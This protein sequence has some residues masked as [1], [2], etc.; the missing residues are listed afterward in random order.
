MAA[1]IRTLLSLFFTVASTLLSFNRPDIRAIILRMPKQ[2]IHVSQA[3]ALSDFA[4]LLTRVQAG[5][6]IIIEDN[7]R[8]VA[9]LTP[10]PLHPGRLLSD[11]ITSAEIC[12][13]N[14]TLD[15][16]FAHD[17]DEIISSHREPMRPPAW[18]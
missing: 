18:E 10:A 1:A 16:N 3:E 4:A 9:I 13:S 14:A 11:A 6:E 8:A 12:G 15:G 2:V 5:M 7:S 17:L